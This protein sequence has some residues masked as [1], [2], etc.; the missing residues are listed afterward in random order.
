MLEYDTFFRPKYNPEENLWPLI[1]GM[2]EA[3]LSHAIALATDLAGGS[4]WARIGGGPGIVSFISEVKKRLEG[5]AYSS[6]II[7]A[8]TGGNIAARLA[9]FQKE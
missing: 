5:M 8:M 7:Q 6:E 1:D 9:V 4:L 3:G 2:V